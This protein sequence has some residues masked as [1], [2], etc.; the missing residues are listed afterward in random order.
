MITHTAWSQVPAI[1]SVTI[2]FWHSHSFPVII[3]FQQFS[4]DLHVLVPTTFPLSFTHLI[5]TFLLTPLILRNQSWLQI[6]SASSFLNLANPNWLNP[7]LCLLHTSTCAA[8]LGERC[9]LISLE[10]S[11]LEC[12][13]VIHFC[14]PCVLPLSWKTVSYPLF[15]T[16]LL[17]PYNPIVYFPEKIGENI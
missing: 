14:F 16:Q 15:S 2:F 1:L 17:L 12:L 3:W 6:H 7:A 13:A 11:D 5:F 9:W 4:W 8:T 10:V